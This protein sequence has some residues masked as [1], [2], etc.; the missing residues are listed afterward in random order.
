MQH[1]AHHNVSDGKK[2]FSHHVADSSSTGDTIVLDWTYQRAQIAAC[3]LLFRDLY[4]LTV[5]A[6]IYQR[7]REIVAP[8]SV[9]PWCACILSRWHGSS[10]TAICHCVKGALQVCFKVFT[11]TFVIIPRTGHAHHSL[12][13]CYPVALLAWTLLSSICTINVNTQAS[14]WKRDLL[15]YQTCILQMNELLRVCKEMHS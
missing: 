14:V 13:S 7:G 12:Y 10:A 9:F 2:L 11:H 1:C 8:L 15:P 6:N 5:S 3:N 4:E